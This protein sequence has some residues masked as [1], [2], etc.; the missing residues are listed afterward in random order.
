MHVHHRCGKAGRTLFAG[1]VRRLYEFALLHGGVIKHTKALNAIPTGHNSYKRLVP[2]FERQSIWVFV[3]KPFAAC[4]FL[5]QQP[6]PGV[7]VPVRSDDETYSALRAAMAGSTGAD[8]IH[9]AYHRQNLYDLPLK[10]RQGSDP[11]ARSRSARNP[12]DR[13]LTAVGFSDDSRRDIALK[14]EEGK[15]FRRRASVEFNVL[16]P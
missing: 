5:R 8:K 2:G 10:S 11:C 4:R 9:P 12:R 1:D 13:N 14:M 6:R 16:Q 7:E 3:A 15:R